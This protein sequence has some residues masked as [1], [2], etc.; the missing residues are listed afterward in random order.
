MG[1]QWTCE[2]PASV[3]WVEVRSMSL[4]LRVGLC[5][6]LS[7]AAS[8]KQRPVLCSSFSNPEAFGTELFTYR[9]HTTGI[10]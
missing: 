4:M 3:T 9:F 2:W 7:R 10:N 8:H 1:S 5:P 6:P